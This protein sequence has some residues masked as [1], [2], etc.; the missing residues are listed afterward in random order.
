MQFSH[1]HNHTQYSLLDGA[2]SIDKL[3]K[4][5]LENNMP[6]VAITDHGN[7]FGVF[8]FVAEAWKK[9]Y[10]KVIGKD[11]NGKDIVEPKIK[12]IIG[13]EFYITEDRFIK[14]FSRPL[15]DKRYHQLLLA[16]NEE[17]YRNLVK[18]N[19]LGFIEGYYDKYPRIDKSLI[20]KYHQG[21]IATTCCLGAIVPRY[22][23][24]KS[25][26]EAEK[27]FE[28]W[29]NIFGEDYY[30][31]LQRHSLK[32]QNQVNEVLLKFAKKYHVKVI[33]TNDSHYIDKDDA[34]GHDILLCVNTGEKQNTP[35][36][37]DFLDGEKTDTKRRFKFPNEEFYFKTPAQMAHLF[38][39]IPE[40][41]DNTNLIVDKIK[42]LNL[43]KEIMLPVYEVPDA[44]KIYNSVTEN[45]FQ[46]LK[47]LAI[48]GSK[49]KYPITTP[50]IEE[51]LQFELSIIHKMKFS[52]YFLIVWDF[53]K[54]AK[55]IGVMVGPGRGSVGG[56][57]VAYCIGITNIDPIKYKLLFERFLNPDRNEMPDI[58]TDFDDEG[59]QKVLNYV[60][61]KYTK[62]Q[63]AHIVT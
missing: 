11:E 41:I 31:E 48:Q 55:E 8:K 21:L 34:D 29:L 35:G 3:Y 36:M 61:E 23:L 26:A 42:S 10:V 59:R 33:A 17:G 54:H 38:Q 27:E 24:E 63:V 12:P 45:Q 22:I 25:E 30:I 47:E 14:S 51:R 28:W 53:V 49:L 7:M 52:G 62:N 19:S 20:E 32:E 13:C 15:K 2:S 16:K 58:D 44:F 6:A 4:K 46:F 1:L 57:V 18:M 60:V 43:V 37:D 39:D 9:D 40:A 5:A 56:S 50:E